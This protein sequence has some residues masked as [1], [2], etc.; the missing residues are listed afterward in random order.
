MA[1]IVVSVAA[2]LIFKGYSYY[3]TSI[4]ERFYH[5]NYHSLK[6]SG[7]IG[8]GL[9]ILGS[10]SMLIGV[11]TYMLRKRVRAFSRWGQLKHWL[12][13]HIFLCT[14]GPLLVLF[15]T[16]F[17]FGGLVSIS[18]W[19]MVA[20][21]ASGVIG[22]YIYV[23]IP[24]TIEGK[25]LSLSEIKDLKND[26]GD[27]LKNNESISEESF[28]LIAEST[29]SRI[30]ITNKNTFIRFLKKY[31]DDRKNL[32]RI[33]G[34]LKKNKLGKAESKRIIGF[35]KNEISINRKI[36][37]LNTMQNLFKYWHVAHL[38]FAIIM[39]VIMIIHVGVTLAFGYKWIF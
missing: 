3:S 19:S 36:D 11:S 16:A 8:H 29:K 6:P 31:F 24:R 9:G 32:K 10:L 37:R 14:L 7:D 38:P 15:H 35:V 33:K 21:F 4:E 18:F 25:E 30:E 5:E 2:L 20:V 17:K 22:R 26:I 27:L 34:S 39:L 23:Q 13:F 1:L 12:E 28:A